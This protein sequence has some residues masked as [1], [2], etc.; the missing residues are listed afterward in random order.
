LY[1]SFWKIKVLSSAHVIG[2]RV[3]KNKLD[4]K[5]NLERYGV[6]LESLLCCLC[7]ANEETRSHLLFGYRI[8][9]LVW[10]LCLEWLGLS[11]V[12]YLAFVSH[13]LQFNIHETPTSV[14]LIL[15]R[16]WIAMVSEIWRH[17]NKHIFNGGVID[18]SEI[19]SMAQLKA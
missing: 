9:W 3:L 2:W 10:N 6:M 13:F 8:A 1:S 5:V 17:R 16:V 14:N 15:E 12:F 11:S 19:F 4:I 7:G 18:Y